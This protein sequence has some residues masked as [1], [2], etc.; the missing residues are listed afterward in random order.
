[1]GKAIFVSLST[2]EK[3]KE[4]KK[5]REAPTRVDRYDYVDRIESNIFLYTEKKKKEKKKTQKREGREKGKRGKNHPQ[6]SHH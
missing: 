5:Q 2:E 6:F 4:E 3:K 1:M